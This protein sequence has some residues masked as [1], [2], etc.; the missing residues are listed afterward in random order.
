[1]AE[2][3]ISVRIISYIPVVNT[4]WCSVIYYS[5]YPSKYGKHNS[6]TKNIQYRLHI[7]IYDRLRSLNRD[8]E[9]FKNPVAFVIFIPIPT[10]NSNNSIGKRVLRAN[11]QT[12]HKSHFCRRFF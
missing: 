10:I 3:S 2:L 9:S 8:R 4:L 7:F 12:E 1:M 6:C 11:V 5:H